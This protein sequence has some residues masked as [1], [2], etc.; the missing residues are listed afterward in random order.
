MRHCLL[1]LVLVLGL[2]RAQGEL[3]A[4]DRCTQ[5]FVVDPD[6]A[7]SLS[8]ELAAQVPATG[9]LS[10]YGQYTISYKHGLERVSALQ[11]WTHKADGRSLPVLP[12]A[13][14]EQPAA[15]E[16]PLFHDI[17]QITVVFPALAPGDRIDVRYTIRRH[18]PLF[19]GHFEDLTAGPVQ[20]AAVLRLIYDLP[21]SLPLQADA[22]G[23]VAEAIDSAPGRL[24]YQW[25]NLPGAS[26]RRE[27][28]AVSPYDQGARLAVSTFPSYAAFARAYG[29]RADAAAQPDDAIR[30]LAQTLSADLPTPRQ[31]VLTLSDWVRTHIRYVASHVGTGS[32]VPHSAASVLAQ[33]YGDCKD[34][35]VLLQALLTA[36]G[37]DSSAALVNADNAY[38]LPGVPTLGILNHVITYVPSLD[39]YLDPTAASIA[40]GYLPVNVLDKPVLLVA[41][42]QQARTPATQRERNHSAL[43]YTLR[44]NGDGQFQLERRTEGA[45]AET[46]DQLLRDARADTSRPLVQRWLRGIGQ[47][48]QGQL[49]EARRAPDGQAYTLRIAGQ[50][51]GLLRRPGP[52][53][54]PTTYPFWGG[55]ADSIAG[56]AREPERRQDFVCPPV[57][58]SERIAITLPPGARVLALPPP[59]RL[60]DKEWDYRATYRQ[61]GRTVEIA[62]SAQF[63]HSGLVC[64]PADYRRMGV[65][66][67][68]MQR[69]LRSPI[70]IR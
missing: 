55:L 49:E 60:Y 61:H 50:S 31:R 43:R 1:L 13:I 38:R 12:E 19:P 48:G 70:L 53:M 3:T 66:L 30:Q 37:I 68:Q 69:D 42:G 16:G 51:E 45:A 17:R 4:P 28:D 18:T 22:V 59:L 57:D 63:R 26:G 2:A 10:D 11:A 44:A 27:A 58:A 25:T 40:A 8:V 20:G 39:L 6:G 65:I 47:R 67:A 15:S 24:R 64:T 46:F 33:G 7:Y 23:F 52:S 29:A 36:I 9:A 14:H 5:H 21:A 56:M 54:L 34:H 32:V 41:S 35:S 62:R